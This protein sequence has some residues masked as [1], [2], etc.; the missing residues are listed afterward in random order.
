MEENS[1]R[2]INI[3]FFSSHPAGITS[4]LNRIMYNKFYENCTTEK[5]SY[6]FKFFSGDNFVTLNFH[7]QNLEMLNDLDNK[8]ENIIIFAYD[9]SKVK[10]FDSLNP[11]YE[12][13]KSIAGDN[14]KNIKVGVIGNKLDLISQNDK[15]TLKEMGE[16][17]AEKINA[18]FLMTSA[19][20]GLG[21]IFLFI[22]SIINSKSKNEIYFKNN[23]KPNIKEYQQLFKSKNLNGI[24]R[25]EK[26]K[27]KIA[28]IIFHD[29]SEKIELCCNEHNDEKAIYTYKEIIN[30]INKKCNI[31]QKEF[32]EKS[33]ESLMYC[34]S[35]QNLI[36][37]KC[38]KRHEHGQNSSENC[39]SYYY[40]KDQLCYIH[41]IKNDLY[42][43]NCN[44]MICIFCYNNAHQEHKV[45]KFENNIIDDLISE[46]RNQLNIQKKQLENLKNYYEILI[47][48]IT[49]LYNEFKD[50]MDLV[51]NLKENVLN[52][53]ELIKY[54][55]EL[56]N[57]VANMKF[58]EIKLDLDDNPNKSSIL[59][60]LTIFFDCIEQPI[61][62]VKYN[63]C[64]GTKV[65]KKY[66]LRQNDK[67]SNNIGKTKLTDACNI[68]GNLCCVGFDDGNIYIYDKKD[69]K[70]CLKS[71]QLYDNNR[72]VNSIINYKNEN[73]IFTSGY[74]K[75]YQLKINKA[76]YIQKEALI[77]QP[78]TNFL[79]LC[80]YSYRKSIVYTD[81]AGN[82]G[83]YNIFDK[84][85]FQIKDDNENLEINSIIDFYNINENAFFMKYLRFELILKSEKVS[86]SP[87]NNRQNSEVFLE[88]YSI[89]DVTTSDASIDDKEKSRELSKIFYIDEQNKIY[90]EHS[91]SETTKIL[92]II[93]KE[94]VV[95]EEIDEKEEIKYK[96]L[97][98]VTNKEFL[99]GGLLSG[100][101]REWSFKLIGENPDDGKIYFVLV[102]Y[103]FNLLEFSIYLQS[104]EI[105]EIGLLRR[106]NKDNPKDP[107]NKIVKIILMKRNFIIVKS[108]GELY[109]MNY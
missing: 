32:D 98:L 23:K 43:M 14:L 25:C 59:D 58:N 16:K 39:L 83:V 8:T 10:P 17:Y 97:N 71:H 13:I 76:L 61:R 19:K 68:D 79:K 70:T 36:C 28:K 21:D 44:S 30:L 104:N 109:V 41:E 5:K 51:L 102:D 18:K 49:K 105:E 52:Q 80:D 7:K 15:K 12:A 35:C 89:I 65:L 64:N 108:N 85:E 27:T 101:K 63:I 99:F 47:N 48:E 50:K 66:N 9:L 95:I 53:L 24:I 55:N 94:Y 77:T 2:V 34:N 22:L 46:K 106:V 1:S 57:T 67:L 37:S 78:D 75:I 20:K 38:I 73:L 103:N 90:N 26:C 74:G 42:C 82:I 33:N 96:I 6:H 69:F 60:K 81:D 54:N 84:Q 56:Y 31:C 107:K 62:I 3:F 92:G 100:I 11:I 4:I 93:N 91:F 86:I 45:K 72:G 40:E 88:R 87:S 29:K